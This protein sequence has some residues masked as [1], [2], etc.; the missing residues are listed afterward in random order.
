MMGGL[1]TACVVHWPSQEYVAQLVMSKGVCDVQGPSQ[2][3]NRVQSP[4]DEKNRSC[5]RSVCAVQSHVDYESIH[6][7]C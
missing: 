5:A 3:S 2:T 4:V 7:T 6:Q 1:G